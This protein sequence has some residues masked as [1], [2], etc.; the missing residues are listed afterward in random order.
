MSEGNGIRPRKL[1]HRR[2][3]AVD[4][5]SHVEHDFKH[6]GNKIT[7]QMFGVPE[8]ENAS[9]R[10]QVIHGKV[11]LNSFSRTTKMRHMPL[12]AKKA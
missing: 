2:D 8:D 9:F 10:F 5:D 6:G 12:S 1:L 11:A 3:K 4:V 7:I